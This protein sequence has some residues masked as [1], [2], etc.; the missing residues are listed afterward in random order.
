MV[1]CFLSIYC[2]DAS[3]QFNF[4]YNSTIISWTLYLEYRAMGTNPAIQ[5][6][7]IEHVEGDTSQVM[8]WNMSCLNAGIGL[9]GIIGGLVVSN[10]NVE[11]VTFVSAFIGLLGLIIVITLKNVHYA[12]INII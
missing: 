7:I 9:G 10:M 6:G 5:S 1:N 8:S 4:I 2:R 11:A 12:K 3:H